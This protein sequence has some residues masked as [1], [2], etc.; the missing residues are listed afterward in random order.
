MQQLN[1]ASCDDP[2][3]EVIQLKFGICEDLIQNFYCFSALQLGGRGLPTATPLPCSGVRVGAPAL[4]LCL[5]LPQGHRPHKDLRMQLLGCCLWNFQSDSGKFQMQDLFARCS[6]LWKTENQRKFGETEDYYDY[7]LWI[8]FK[9]ILQVEEIVQI[10]SQLHFPWL[11][12]KHFSHCAY[13]NNTN[14]LINI[15][16]KVSVSTFHSWES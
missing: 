2:G 5:A 9:C 4:L 14:N 6:G 3:G 12:G 1:L 15:F 7:R 16:F 11:I 10:T 8:I 13:A